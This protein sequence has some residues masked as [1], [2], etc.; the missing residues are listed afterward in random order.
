LKHV[1][2]VFRV[3]EKSEVREVTSRRTF[4]TY[5][6]VDATVGDETG[7]V[8][9]PLW[10]ETIESIDIGKTYRLENG[11][12]GLFRGN[13]QLKI[14]RHSELK[15]A[16]NEIGNVNLNVDMSSKNHRRSQPRHYYQSY[17]RTG[18][19]GEAI[20]SVRGSRNRDSRRD[21]YGRRRRRW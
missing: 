9:L 13:L 4:E 17:E 2:L 15:D 5:R 12:T 1:D 3:I 14:G 21:H 19:R 6:I 20:Y 18:N 8:K 10:N 11:Y 7:I 16:E